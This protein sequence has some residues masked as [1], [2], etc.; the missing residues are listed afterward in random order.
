MRQKPNSRM[1]FFGLILIFVSFQSF[2]QFE[3]RPVSVALDNTE[4]ECD[5]IGF[6]PTS[7][8]KTKG[9]NSMGSFYIEN[10]GSVVSCFINGDKTLTFDWRYEL[11]GTPL[12]DTGLSITAFGEFG[13]VYELASVDQTTGWT[14]VSVYLPSGVE[15]VN[16][17]L[18]P[19]ES[20]TKGWVDNLRVQNGNQTGGNNGSGQ[21]PGS[22]K[23]P[24]ASNPLSVALDN[25]Y[26]DF[27]TGGD[28]SFNVVN[29]SSTKGGSSLRSG[30]VNDNQFSILLGLVPA[31]REIKFDWRVSSETNYDFLIFYFLDLEGN[32]ISDIDFITGTK[33]WATLSRRIPGEGNVI[34]AW[35]YVKDEIVSADSD[36]GWVDNVRISNSAIAAL[37]GILQL[38]LD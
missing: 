19:N 5:A 31:G 6:S 14:T 30:N 15:S 37:P 23:G 34:A 10:T 13:K 3:A 12:P 1:S 21:Q 25:T 22:D 18:F 9:T 28:A 16:W 32:L 29:N 2:A 27:A 35:A 8:Y 26:Y 20:G 17:E 24:F 36:S 4:Y 11:S 7:Q 38:L 33:S